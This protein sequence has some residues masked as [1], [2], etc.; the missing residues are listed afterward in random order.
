MGTARCS[1]HGGTCYFNDIATLTFV[2][3]EP[4]LLGRHALETLLDRSLDSVDTSDAEPVEDSLAELVVRSTAAFIDQFGASWRGIDTALE[5]GADRLVD[6]A[7][8]M[9]ADT[10]VVVLADCHCSGGKHP[11]KVR[12]RQ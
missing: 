11:A 2:D 1:A 5:G 4:S 3:G 9:G 10:G 7:R 12:L 6:L 8:A